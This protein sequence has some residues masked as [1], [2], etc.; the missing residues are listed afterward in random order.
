MSKLED[1]ELEEMLELAF[2]GPRAICTESRSAALWYPARLAWKDFSDDSL[3]HN[4]EQVE[5]LLGR[6]Y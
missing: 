5:I 3:T 1:D 6:Q 4:M 2:P